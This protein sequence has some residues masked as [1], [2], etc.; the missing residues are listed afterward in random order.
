MRRLLITCGLFAAA[1]ATP[2]LASAQNQQNRNNNTGSSG[3]GSTGSSGF[4]SNGSS[5]F[6]STGS[7][8]FGSTGASGFGSNSG[9]GGQAGGFGANG[10]TGLG[11]QGQNGAN[12]NGGLLGRGANQ[13]G[14]LG[15]NVQNQGMQ[16]N[17]LGG[18][19]GG[20]GGGGNR[21]G[22]GL[23]GLNGGG[24]NGGNANQTPIVRPRQKIAFEYTLPTSS[25]IQSTI[26][27]RL[28]KLSDKRHSLKS[29][30]VAVEDKGEV[31]LRGE[32]ASADDAKLAENMLRQ[33]PGVRSVRNELSFPAPVPS[34]DE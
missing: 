15:R 22:N 20:R 9:A 33:E 5:G 32:V 14:F 16:G 28:T 12:A 34:K 10:Q 8:G 25:A 11:G 30:M 27:A 21:G 17:N 19:G 1:C 6:G 29:V 4:G 26:E 7:S 13:S 18:G 2:D 3:F 31:V 24:G 23:N